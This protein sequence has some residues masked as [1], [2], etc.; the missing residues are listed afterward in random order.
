MPVRVRFNRV[1][2]D[3]DVRGERKATLSFILDTGGGSMIFSH[4][5]AERAGLRPTS[6]AV[7]QEGVRMRIAASPKLNV[8]GVPIAIPQGRAVILTDAPWAYPGVHASGA[9]PVPLVR[10]HVVVLDYPRARLAVDVPPDIGAATV[11]VEIHEQTGFIRVPMTMAG[12]RYFFLLDT[13]GSCCMFS[14]VIIEQLRQEHPDWPLVHGA[15]GYGNMLGGEAEA[16]AE[17]LLVS[18]A[19]IAGIRLP[20][21]AVV[22]RPVGTYERWMSS[23]MT[24]EV[25]GSISGN[26]LRDFRLRI[27]YA[28]SRVSF[29]PT[30]HRHAG[31]F[32]LVPVTLTPHANGSYTVAGAL[33]GAQFSIPAA[34][35]IGKELRSVDGQ[36]VTGR[37]LEQVVALLRGQ[38]PMQKHLLFSDGTSV[39]GPVL[40]LL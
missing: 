17:M 13:G 12:K 37:T 11:A 15:Y 4:P 30:W 16:S 20:P 27:D 2:A 35:F 39:I 21:F 18:G 25:V 23:M 5:A 29:V 8:A 31:D 40:R 34:R 28:R 22:S 1:I 10:P 33:A 7:M 14:R 19:S 38:P 32:D 36:L 24:G 6:P 26:L 9:F 3:L